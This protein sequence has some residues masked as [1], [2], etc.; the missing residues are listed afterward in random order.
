MF[1]DIKYRPTREGNMYVAVVWN[2]NLSTLLYAWTDIFLFFLSI[3]HFLTHGV[4]V[5]ERYVVKKKYFWK[6]IIAIH[7]IFVW[8]VVELEMMDLVEWTF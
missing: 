3:V 6:S 5:S 8:Y 1:C 2:I 4:S 7:E